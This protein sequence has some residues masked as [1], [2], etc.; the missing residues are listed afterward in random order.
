[1]LLNCDNMISFKMI[2]IISLLFSCLFFLTGCY[3]DVIEEEYLDENTEISFSGDVIPIFENSCISC[4]GSNYAS[5]V[6]TAEK[7]YESLTS[8]GFIN[9]EDPETSILVEQLSD[10]HPYKGAVTDK[11]LQMIVLWIKQGAYDN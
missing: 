1:M 5:P 2:S 4:H 6:L 7:A 11:E 8:G 10:D 9:T 3:S